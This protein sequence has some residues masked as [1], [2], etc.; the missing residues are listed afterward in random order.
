[1]AKSKT[2][3]MLEALLWITQTIQ[4]QW[5]IL[6]KISK[7]L[8]TKEELPEKIDEHKYVNTM[9]HT[10]KSMPK[11]IV[12]YKILLWVKDTTWYISYDPQA[13]QHMIFK[14]KEEML[15]FINDNNIQDYKYNIIRA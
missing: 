10:L 1:M 15:N 11:G 14:T 3:L 2:D 12:W 13:Y 4:K 9:E 8:E 6:E 5:E 7:K